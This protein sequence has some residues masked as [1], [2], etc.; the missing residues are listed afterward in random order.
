MEG[1]EVV[2]RFN[3]LKITVKGRIKTYLELDLLQTCSKSIFPLLSHSLVCIKNLLF[4]IGIGPIL[5]KELKFIFWSERSDRTC[6]Y[7]YVSVLY[8]ELLDIKT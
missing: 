8:D 5:N 7:S 3:L 4:I 6:V 2:T 1:K